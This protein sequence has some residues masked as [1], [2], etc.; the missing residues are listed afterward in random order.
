MVIAHV[1]DLLEQLQGHSPILST[2]P[3]DGAVCHLV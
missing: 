1:L 2:C 3:H